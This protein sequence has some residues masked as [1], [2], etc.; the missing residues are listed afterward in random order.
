VYHIS[1]KIAE[2]LLSKEQYSYLRKTY[3]RIKRRPL[4]GFLCVLPDCIILGAMKCGTSSLYFYLASHPQ[5]IT[6]TRKEIHFFDNNFEK[7]VGWYRSHFPSIA[8]MK[9]G[10]YITGEASPYY[11]YHPHVARRIYQTIPNVKLIALLR[12]PVDRAISHYWHQVNKGREDLP[13]E[14]AFEVEKE[15]ISAD[16]ERL[17][18]EKQYYGFNHRH[19]SYLDRGKY[20]GQIERFERRF[21]SDQILILKSEE[22]FF[23][24]KETIEE[25][26]D[27][28]GIERAEMEVGE[29]RNK[30]E[31]G[32]EAPKHV[33]DRLA[34]Y[35]R[36]Q[37]AQIEEKYGIR[38]E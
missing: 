18:K 35:Y 8:K 38:F 6:P 31:Y 10:I 27:F 25:V 2:N 12:N 15:R 33:R 11:L 37:K 20:V 24:A 7:K 4:P 19:Y 26:E 29:T 5:V 23:N 28:L 9:S 1:K 16:K 17:K 14:E 36:D 22:L 21:S 3:S 32:R 30:G 13:M 34:A